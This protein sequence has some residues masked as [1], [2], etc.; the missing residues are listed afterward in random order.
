MRELYDR[1]APVRICNRP[2]ARAPAVPAV[3]VA[4]KAGLNVPVINAPWT[5]SF[6]SLH[7]GDNGVIA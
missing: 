2:V 3:A 5:G 4:Q 7:T 1:T 6:A